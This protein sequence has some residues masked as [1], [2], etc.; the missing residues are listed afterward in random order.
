NKYTLENTQSSKKRKLIPMKCSHYNFNTI[1]CTK[2]YENLVYVDF[3]KKLLDKGLTSVSLLFEL[4]HYNFNKQKDICKMK[5]EEC[6]HLLVIY[7]I[8]IQQFETM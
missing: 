3:S 1:Q 7:T 5:T 4:F 2:E 6:F 8:N